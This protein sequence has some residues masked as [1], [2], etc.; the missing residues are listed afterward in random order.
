MPCSMSQSSFKFV[1]TD[2][3]G[4]LSGC[5]A[6]NR[7]SCSCK[8][9]LFITFRMLAVYLQSK[10]HWHLWWWFTEEWVSFKSQFCQQWPAPQFPPFWGI[11][12]H[13]DL[14][15]VT[16]CLYGIQSAKAISGCQLKLY[17][18]SKTFVEGDIWHQHFPNWNISNASLWISGMQESAWFWVLY[19]HKVSIQKHFLHKL[20]YQI[21]FAH[22]LSSFGKVIS[23]ILFWVSVW[24]SSVTWGGM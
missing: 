6:W 8:L 21:V 23:D 9:Q 3:G 15:L 4:N 24:A 14:S 5:L 12:L 10:T 18:R 20:W 13:C 2:S 1:A 16:Y 7:F 11:L 17:V 22:L 19:W